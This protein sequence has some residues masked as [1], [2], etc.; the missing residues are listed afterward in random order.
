MSLI[1]DYKQLTRNLQATTK[2]VGSQADVK[3]LSAQYLERIGKIK[4][5]DDFMNDER[6]YNYA[7]TAFGLKDMI[8]AKALIRKVL[9]EGVDSE[10]AFSVRMADSR[11]KEFAETFNFARYKAATTSFERT[12]QGTVDRYVR[13]TMEEQ[14]GRQDE[15]LRLALYFQRKAPNVTGAYGILADKA[16]YTVV[17]TALGLSAATSSSDITKQAQLIS[18][19]VDIADFTNPEKLDKFITR[20]MARA[21]AENSGFS[22]GTTSVPAI[23]ILQGIASN[24]DLSTLMSIQTLK[25]HNG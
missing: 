12:Q 24:V 13:N 5:V 20:F 11:F 1:T 9:V 23:G 15:R 22:S 19:K 17:R 10:R 4:S 21:M 16:L 25:R 3:R 7:L 8:Y 14:A 6:V 18:S 2:Q